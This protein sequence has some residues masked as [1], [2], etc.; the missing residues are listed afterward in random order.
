MGTKGFFQFKI[1]INVLVSSSSFIW[2]MLWVYSHYK[3]FYLYIA[4]QMIFFTQDYSAGIKFRL[5][6]LMS[7]IVSRALRVKPGKNFMAVDSLRFT[8]NINQNYIILFIVIQISYIGLY[9]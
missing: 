9:V 4:D 8:L 3:Y 7:Q 2:Y 6:N 1:I 5:Q